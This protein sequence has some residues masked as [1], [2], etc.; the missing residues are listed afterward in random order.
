[1]RTISLLDC[2]LR[3]G[4][5]VNDWK[6]GRNNL[7]S[8]FE[9]LVASRVD[10][11][12][13]GFIDESRP[14]DPDRAIFP[15]A[16]SISKTFGDLDKGS[17]RIVG[18]I[19]YGHASLDKICDASETCIDTIRVIFKKHLREDALVFV[20]ELMK[21][22]YRVFAQLV[23]ITSYSDEELKDLIRIANEVK[24]FAVSM[25]DTYGL[26]HSDTLL[27]YMELLD[28]GLDPRIEI[29]YH[30]HNNFQLGYAHCIEMLSY[31]T[32]RNVLVDGTIFGMGKSAGNCPLELIAMYLNGRHGKD[33]DIYQ[34]LE[35]ADANVMNFYHRSPWGYSIFF[36]IAASNDCHPSYVSYLMNKRTLSIKAVNKILK[37]LEGDKKLL[38]DEKLIEKLYS[39]YQEIEVN[40]EE[41]RKRLSGEL[42][43]KKVLV[44]G[45]GTSVRNE[46]DKV[47]SFI[48][49]NSPEIIS[50][51]F[52][53]DGVKPDYCF[54]TNKKRFVQLSTG[55]AK[56]RDS[57]KV[58]AT[59]N[60]T[61]SVTEFDY[62]IRYSNLLDFN[63]QI[64]DNSFLMLL[65]LLKNIGVK[66][67]FCAGF[68][69]YALD[70]RPNY[71]NPD[72]EYEFT[73]NEASELNDY[74]IGQLKDL[75]DGF[76]INFVTD[77]H[78]DV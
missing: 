65:K 13:I 43:D 53:P 66:E 5:Y 25:V 23:S 30:A 34:I 76:K 11:I 21:K 41:D 37:R 3:D 59:S 55:L 24:P 77:S 15:D 47:G 60:V 27:H 18:M 12:E 17:S 54:V 46:S 28:N 8:I 68:D 1:M 10:Y 9:R 19:D 70:N 75:S 67:V 64:I 2:T 22:G 32:D 72:M 63:A 40:D 33:Y 31:K 7:I 39:D 61:S 51:N 56:N 36:Y 29:G 45:P 38:Y 4:G 58:I 49:E 73:Y 50:I 62:T 6:F 78:Y 48:S 74:V 52:I 42:K 71:F 57:F 35:A 69:G 44:L 26:C 16:A 20:S 14:Y